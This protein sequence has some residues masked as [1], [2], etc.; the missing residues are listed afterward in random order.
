MKYLIF[1]LLFAAAIFYGCGQSDTRIA[2]AVLTPISHPSLEQI[3]RGFKQT[4]EAQN[5]GKFRFVTYNA[6]GNKTLMHSEVEEIAQ[7]DY[8]LVFTIGTLASQ[9]VKESF[10]K[11]RLQ[12]PIVFT[13]VNDPVAFHLVTSEAHPG[14]NVT[15][16]KETV[17][18][19]AEIA[20]LL[21]YK[22]TIK[23]LLLVYNPAEPGM[24]KDQEEIDVLLKQ[25]GIELI[26]VEIFQSNEIYAKV[27]PFMV[28][29]DALMILKDNN[30]V[31][32]EDALIKLCNRHAIPLM[33][34]ELDSPNRGAAFGYGV[35]E[36]EY[37]NEAGKKAHTI[38]NDGVAA[39]TIPVTAVTQFTLKVNGEAARKQG[40][41]M[42]K[43]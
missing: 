14:G 3:E 17:N 28:K 5:P 2:I 41:A 19:Q 32:A 20:A 27:E 42:E 43:N 16:V 13:A 36:I 39:G 7:R 4:L 25:L 26:A 22:P 38:L 6:Q 37:G 8:A 30:V 1:L 12:T 24:Q 34:S 23:S 21:K 9:M 40:I 33:A 35:F 10:S 15:G 31:A 29:A 18:F 11:K